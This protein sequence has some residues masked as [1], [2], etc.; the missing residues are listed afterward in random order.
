MDSKKAVLK[1][2]KDQNRPYSLNDIFMNM[3]K[4]QGKTAI[5]KALD[6]LVVDGVV[7]EKTYGKQKV[8]AYNQ[9]NE[10]DNSVSDGV[11]DV[12]SEVQAVTEELAKTEKHLREADRILSELNSSLTT[13][14]AK[15]ELV[16]ISKE[17]DEM[18][19]EL[20]ALKSGKEIIPPSVCEEIIASHKKMVATWKKRKHQCMQMVSA[21]TENLPQNRKDFMSELGM[22]TDE[23]VNIS[24]SA[25]ESVQ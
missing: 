9:K 3:H 20:D 4:E 17:L 11:V 2:L 21:V 24:L 12:D 15:K 22:E 8:Y 18:R 19:E 5:Q 23:D 7:I 25:M 10:R 1:Y 13:D 6:N 14:D 16:R